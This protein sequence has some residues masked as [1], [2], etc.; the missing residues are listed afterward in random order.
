M[1]EIKV[2]V[3]GGRDFNNYQD[4][5][6]VL[7]HY[8]DK[9]GDE[10]GLSIVCGGARGADLMGKL[11]SD[12][13]N[14]QI[15]HFPAD[16]NTHGKSAGYRRNVEMADFADRLIAFWDNKSKGT[17]HMINIMN[18]KRKPVELIDYAVVNG[19]AQVIPF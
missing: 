14:A 8:A 17:N 2:I 11:F 3:A 18:Q 4:A 15:Y 1:E 16:W 13:H 7:L 12:K 5:E 19:V 6:E 10:Y 9:L